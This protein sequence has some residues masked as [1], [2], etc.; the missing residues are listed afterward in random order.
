VLT[1]KVNFILSTSVLL[2]CLIKYTSLQLG[3]FVVH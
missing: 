2:T 1:Q 3:C